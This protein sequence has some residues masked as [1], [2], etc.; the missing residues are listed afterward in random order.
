MY[1]PI[2]EFPHG[3]CD[4][5]VLGSPQLPALLRPGEVRNGDDEEAVGRVGNTGQGVVPRQ[6]CRQD[7]KTTASAEAV[8]VGRAVARL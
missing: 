5:L 4:V 6:E 7:A 2:F 3:L 8:L 1:A